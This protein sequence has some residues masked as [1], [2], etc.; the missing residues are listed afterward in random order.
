MPELFKSDI[1]NYSDA[2]GRPINISGNTFFGDFA[3]RCYPARL[4]L[5]HVFTSAQEMLD[6]G[7]STLEDNASHRRLTHPSVV[8]GKLSWTDI[9]D[10]TASLDQYLTQYH[11]SPSTGFEETTTPPAKVQKVRRDTEYHECRFFLYLSSMYYGLHLMRVEDFGD[12]TRILEACRRCVC[13]AR[14]TAQSLC[15]ILCGE[16]LV[17]V[18]EYGALYMS[19]A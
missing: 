15:A 18:N 19:V 9:Q 4:S 16:E 1:T 8:S 5:H 6:K 2:V 11:A 10:R 17:I 7:T 12:P 13:Y 14:K 3:K